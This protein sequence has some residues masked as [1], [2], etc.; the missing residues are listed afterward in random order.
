MKHGPKQK[1]GRGGKPSYRNEQQTSHQ[2][3]RQKRPNQYQQLL[4]PKKTFEHL[5]LPDGFHEKF[6]DILAQISALNSNG[7]E[8][9]V[10]QP[11]WVGIL[12]QT[13]TAISF[14]QMQNIARPGSKESFE[15]QYGSA[16]SAL[17][18]AIRDKTLLE[19]N[20]LFSEALL[21][22]DKSFLETL[23]RIIAKATSKM[24]S[25]LATST[26]A[27]VN[28]GA[29][30]MEA[31]NKA[32]NFAELADA[33]PI[34]VCDSTPTMEHLEFLH[35]L[36][37]VIKSDRF[38]VVLKEKPSSPEILLEKHP[39]FCQEFR[40]IFTIHANNVGSERALGDIRGVNNFIFSVKNDAGFNKLGINPN[41]FLPDDPKSYQANAFYTNGENQVV[42]NVRLQENGDVAQSSPGTLTHELLHFR[43]CKA[44]ALQVKLNENGE[45]ENDTEPASEC[46]K[47]IFEFYAYN[48]HPCMTEK[49]CPNFLKQLQDHGL[50]EWGKP[51]IFPL[52]AMPVAFSN[53]IIIG[54][55]KKY[56]IDATRIEDP[57]NGVF[58]LE[59]KQATT[60]EQKAFFNAYVRMSYAKT[61]SSATISKG[62]LVA[63]LE[64]EANIRGGNPSFVVSKECPDLTESY[65]DKVINKIDPN[66][67]VLIRFIL[68]TGS[69]AGG[70]FT[71]SEFSKKL[72]QHGFESG[73]G[74]S[75]ILTPTEYDALIERA[76]K[77]L[78]GAPPRSEKQGR[79]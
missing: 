43:Q 14:A 59:C 16:S 23:P 28:A 58:F 5:Y 8:F 55:L 47:R 78:Y 68:G 52:E 37:E 35:E 25:A 51:E 73:E 27:A 20:P 69:I 41:P 71:T 63:I 3:P 72:E 21:E 45:L 65:L 77:F 29:S 50:E 1:G 79:T 57:K 31:L 62:G 40:R 15:A 53:N 54:D 70:K 39:K 6:P 38:A 56:G 60:K 48:L 49:E 17:D 64:P 42:V 44:G 66:S 12:V 22:A 11:W 2:D 19:N 46:I 9:V 67:N 33:R 13:L 30:A 10:K 34:Q 18:I 75:R 61:F 76:E 36:E 26:S 7:K 74:P 4:L 24:T 32:T